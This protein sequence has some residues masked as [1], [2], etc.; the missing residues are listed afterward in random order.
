MHMRLRLFA[1][2]VVVFSVFNTYGQIDKEA[3]KA[4]SVLFQKEQDQHYLDKKTSPLTK[5][6]RKKFE[7]HSFYS[8]DLGYVVEASFERIQEADT[9]E[10]PTSS[11][12]IKY[13]MPYAKLSFQL[14]GEKCE[15]IAYQSIRLRKIKEYQNYLFIPFRDATSGRESYGGGRYLDVEIPNGNKII[16]NFNKAYNP[17]CA[18]T[19]GYN[20]T[21]PPKAN[22]LAVSVNAGLKAPKFL[23]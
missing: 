17:Y 19:V 11:G 21:I 5:K 10:M 18:Y 4:E 16:L 1:I 22:T 7:G 14:Q 15:L 13:Y 2:A 12:L 9:V 8:I 3:Y 6:E 20:C 23:H